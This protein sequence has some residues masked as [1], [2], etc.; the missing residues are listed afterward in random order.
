MAVRNEAINKT[1]IGYIF[2]LLFS[3]LFIYGSNLHS[4]LIPGLILPFIIYLLFFY[5]LKNKALKKRR[6]QQLQIK[7]LK[8][9]FVEQTE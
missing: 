6:L 2:W 9:D 8:Q 7:L 5:Y 1:V 4:I 3:V